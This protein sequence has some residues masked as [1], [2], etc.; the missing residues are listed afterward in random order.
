MT[1]W[2]R[3]R[4]SHVC[5][6]EKTGEGSDLMYLKY[7]Y[8]NHPSYHWIWPREFCVQRY[9]YKVL[10]QSSYCFF[11]LLTL[12]ISHSNGASLHSDWWQEYDDSDSI[13]NSSTMPKPVCTKLWTC[14][15]VIVSS[16][17]VVR[18]YFTAVRGD[19]YGGGVIIE[20]GNLI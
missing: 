14:S 16:I 2:W 18:G 19:L 8:S 20:A 4:V 11:L 13:S 12:C 10:Q 1:K 15:H 7:E 17:F 3:E 9:R 5:Q 6:A